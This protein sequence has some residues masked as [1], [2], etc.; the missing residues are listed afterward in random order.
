MSEQ[1]QTELEKSAN[2]YELP[3]L[4]AE[5]VPT[6]AAD[7]ADSEAKPQS[8]D[9]IPPPPPPVGATTAP[10]PPAIPPPPA[11]LPVEQLGPVP[12]PLPVEPVPVSV[13]RPT[14]P[15][16]G[17]G[18]GRVESI[19]G[20]VSARRSMVG[21]FLEGAGTG[22]GGMASQGCAR[23]AHRLAR[24]RCGR[25]A[26]YPCS[27]PCRPQ[28]PAP[29][30]APNIAAHASVH[31]SPAICRCG[32]A[33]SCTASASASAAPGTP[34]ARSGAGHARTAHARAVQ[35]GGARNAA[36]T[37]AAR[38]AAGDGQAHVGCRGQG[39]SGRAPGKASYGTCF[40]AA[41]LPLPRPV[42]LLTRN[43]R[44]EPQG[45]SCRPRTR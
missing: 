28:S 42:Q 44:F 33:I 19:Y 15:S 38:P 27:C 25:S 43:A 30:T 17:P 4:P 29:A 11:P 7:G 2:T 5:I 22:A 41:P 37:A 40:S 6:A 35:A 8:T 23:V 10:L 39:R 9:D 21:T 32:P 34:S 45:A 24:P 13:G 36:A 18:T 14:P 31:A 1:R 3:P 12:A 20:S 16:L 26:P